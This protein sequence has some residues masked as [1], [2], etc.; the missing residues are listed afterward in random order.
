[1]QLHE[2]Y[3]SIISELFKHT[4]R[5]GAAHDKYFQNID[6]HGPTSSWVIRT[7]KNSNSSIQHH[8]DN[9]NEKEKIYWFD[10]EIPDLNKQVNGRQTFHTIFRDPKKRFVSQVNHQTAAILVSYG[11]AINNW[12]G[13]NNI[14]SAMD[15]HWLP[16][17]F[18]L[19]VLRESKLGQKI[20]YHITDTVES[21][22]H[23]YYGNYIIKENWRSTDF[24]TN[25]DFTSYLSNTEDDFKFIYG[26]KNYMTELREQLHEED[27]KPNREYDYVNVNN[28]LKIVHS[29]DDRIPGYVEKYFKCD[30]LVWEWLQKREN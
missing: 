9:L 28:L 29:E 25:L 14:A 5:Y 16:Q 12:T 11:I 30:Q 23:Q 15:P 17:C 18:F 20:L 4:L 13:F 19:P 3:F 8:F 2:K 21:I 1:M 26:E 27:V 10:K 24:L 22:D 6:Y 7:L